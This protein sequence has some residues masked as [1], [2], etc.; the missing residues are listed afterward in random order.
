MYGL[1]LREASHIILVPGTFHE[2]ASNEVPMMQSQKPKSLY[3]RS[4][5]QTSIQQTSTDDSHSYQNL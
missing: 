5:F 3:I 4:D 2:Q 1:L